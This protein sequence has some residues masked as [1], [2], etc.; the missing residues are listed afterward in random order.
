MNYSGL[1]R[2]DVANG[3]GMRVTLFVSGCSLHCP[4]C[5]NPEAQ[6]KNFGLKFTKETFDIICDELNKTYNCGFTLTGG[7]PLEHYN[8][9]DCTKLCKKIKQLFPSKSIW[10]YSGFIYEDVKDLEIFDYVDVFVDGKFIKELHDRDLKW[11]GSSNQRVIDVKKSL[12]SDKVILYEDE[13]V[14]V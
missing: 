8:L 13:L 10:L 2:N 7:H 4:F 12:I 9:D 14:G 3:E 6:N 5:H 1:I 11:R